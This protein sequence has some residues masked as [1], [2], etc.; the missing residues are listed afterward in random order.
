MKYY[1]LG[2]F[3]SIK[4]IEEAQNRDPCTYGYLI[5]DKMSWTNRKVIFF[6]IKKLCWDNTIS[7]CTGKKVDPCITLNTKFNFEL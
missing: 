5:Y 1:S 6:Q 2:I 3:K 7:T 4:R